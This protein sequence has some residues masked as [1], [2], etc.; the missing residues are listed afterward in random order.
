MLNPPQATDGD[1]TSPQHRLDAFAS[2]FSSSEGFIHPSVELV[3]S[4][5]EGVHLSIK[6]SISAPIF[7]D[8]CIIRCPHSLTLSAL[9]VIDVA[10]L[11][12]ARDNTTAFP[13]NL[14]NEARPQSVAA[15]CLALHWIQRDRS[16]WA[17]Y[18]KCLP[19]PPHV[20]WDGIGVIDTP[21]WWPH[22]ER[23]WIAGTNLERGADALEALW[24]QEWGSFGT[25][26]V[27][28]GNERGVALTW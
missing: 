27:E 7:S 23:A 3:H 26:M 19:G 12:P 9:N 21:L 2:W 20:E 25:T 10:P 28:W 24:R 14:L 17:A 22:E 18:L 11:F 8:T 15:L 4:A 13:R 16:W 1:M 6:S 5:V